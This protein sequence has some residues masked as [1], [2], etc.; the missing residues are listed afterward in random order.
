[1]KEYPTKTKFIFVADV[2]V[3]VHDTVKIARHKIN[4]MTR[5]S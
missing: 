2:M 1:M 5:K 3:T 4:L